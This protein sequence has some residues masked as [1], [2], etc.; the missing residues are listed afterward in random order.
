MNTRI[1]KR[2]HS[3]LML[4]ALAASVAT[5]PVPA[6]A[7]SRCEPAAAD[8]PALESARTDIDNACFCSDF[9]GSDGLGRSEFRA[10]VRDQIALAVE[11]S[12]VRKACRGTLKKMYAASVCGTGDPD[13]EPCIETS[14]AG[15]VRCR[16]RSQATCEERAGLVCAGRPTCIDA[17]DTSGDMA[18]DE[19]DT[20][21]CIATAPTTTLPPETT[22]TSTTEEPTTTTT[23]EPSPTT[24]E[25]PTTTTTMPVLCGEGSPDIVVEFTND[26]HYEVVGEGDGPNCGAQNLGGGGCQLLAVVDGSDDAATTFHADS[27]TDERVCSQDDAALSYQW[28]FF[29]PT[30]IQA[31]PYWPS[32][33]TGR[34]SP[35][36]TIP[37]SS[38]PYLEDTIAGDDT[39]FRAR[40]T[41]TPLPLEGEEITPAPTILWF[42][43][44]YQNTDL[45]LD[46]V[47]DI[48]RPSSCNAACREIHRGY[49]QKYPGRCPWTY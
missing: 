36:I 12:L 16:I 17:A 45:N 4:L 9:D 35:V 23:Q 33:L 27:T 6:G 19:N 43:F 26:D 44:E 38:F 42:R 25:E 14:A 3:V 18:V 28:D 20:G 37:P 21:L 15:A 24:T 49:C 39:F 34:N 40:L 5:G 32:W 22:T 13:L 46:L 29:Y 10:C 7:A 8:A 48:E 30:T 11:S 1:C 41:V 47:I 2:R 31:R